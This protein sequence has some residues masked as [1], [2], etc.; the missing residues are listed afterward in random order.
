M[1]Y[2][3]DDRI[4]AYMHAKWLSGHCVKYKQ[5]FISVLDTVKLLVLWNKCMGICQIMEINIQY[6]K[7]FFFYCNLSNN[8]HHR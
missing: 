5:T 3:Q 1:G 2:S 4:G 6:G 7:F 8:I